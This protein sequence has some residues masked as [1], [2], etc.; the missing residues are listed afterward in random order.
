MIGFSVNGAN[1]TIPHIVHPVI[2]V[3]AF[4]NFSNRVKCTVHIVYLGK[5]LHI[6]HVYCIVYT[7]CTVVP[8]QV[9]KNARGIS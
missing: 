8:T 2:F 6:L 5:C 3:I 4:P 7:V 1:V 9:D